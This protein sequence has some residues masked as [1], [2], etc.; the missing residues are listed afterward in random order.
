MS[1]HGQL[2]AALVNDIGAIARSTV[3]VRW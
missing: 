1:D 2:T 3:P